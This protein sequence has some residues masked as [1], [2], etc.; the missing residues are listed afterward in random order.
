VNETEGTLFIRQGKGKKDRIVP[1]GRVA[2]KWL[3]KYLDEMRRYYA[4]SYEQALFVSIWSGE[5]LGQQSV[6]E[7]IRKYRK[8]C[9]IKKHIHTHAFRHTCATH[10]LKNGADIRYVQEMLGHTSAHTTEIYTHL[11]ITDLKPVITR[12][13]PR[14]KLGT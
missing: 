1:V 13:H 3:K 12:C 11:D 5:R 8:G 14:S 4:A 9:T 10:M 2:M 7:I 6:A